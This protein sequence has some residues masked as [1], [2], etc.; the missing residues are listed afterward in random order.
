MPTFFKKYFFRLPM[1]KISVSCFVL[2]LVFQAC[3]EIYDPDI[4][5][6][7]SYLVV[8]GLISDEE[9]QHRV[10]LSRTNVFGESYQ[11]KPVTLADVRIHDSRGNETHLTE[12][13]AGHYLTPAAFSGQPGETYTLHIETEDGSV[14]HSDPQRMM[15]PVN[16]DTI[17][18][19]F[20]TQRFFFESQVSGEL[21]QRE[22]EGVNMLMDVS[23]SDGQYP[24]FRFA[25][26]MLL[27]YS[28][29]LGIDEFEFCWYK[30]DITEILQTDIGT[31]VTTSL[32]GRN[33]FAFFPLTTTNMR[34]L[35]FPTADNNENFITYTHPRV[36]MQAIYT[37]NDDAYAFH[38]ARNQQISDEG[39][40]FD[41]I[42]PQL[43]S[44][45]VNLHDPDEVV[46]GFFEASSLVRTTMNVKPRTHTG[47]I[48][49]DFLNCM[50][51]VPSSGCSYM[52]FPDWWI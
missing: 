28:N 5:P 30:R 26:S 47:I 29:M 20:A 43:P 35:G 23:C 38:R 44:N 19:E 46:I 22:V 50:H 6:D 18:A 49:I 52:E 21:L 39:S 11:F 12:N 34:H 13:I 17:Y 32:S 25:T 1:L 40:L 33:R 9:G 27:Q 8:E 7:K 24:R 48:E 42:A 37:L 14:Y 51:H 15:A 2:V 36:L 16:V 4:S 41:P 31:D 45:I 3:R 10:R